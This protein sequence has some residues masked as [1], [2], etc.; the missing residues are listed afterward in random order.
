MTDKIVSRKTKLEK[1][2]VAELRFYPGRNLRTAPL[3]RL[4][5][6]FLEEPYIKVFTD[7]SF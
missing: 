7:F 5:I 3:K 2:I 1:K 6:H 4:R